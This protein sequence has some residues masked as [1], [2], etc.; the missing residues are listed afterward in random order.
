MV[1]AVVVRDRRQ[2]GIV[3]FRERDEPVKLRVCRACGRAHLAAAM[4][5]RPAA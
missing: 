2:G 4:D 5:C 1:S 3:H